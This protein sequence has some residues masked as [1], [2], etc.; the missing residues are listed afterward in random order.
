MLKERIHYDHYSDRTGLTPKTVYYVVKQALVWRFYVRLM[1]TDLRPCGNY[2]NKI[3][4]EFMRRFGFK[5]MPS[6]NS[7]VEGMWYN[8]CKRCR[9]DFEEMLGDREVIL[10]NTEYEPL[11]ELQRLWID[12]EDTWK[13]L[14][15]EEY[16]KA[17]QTPTGPKKTYH[18][19]DGWNVN[20]RILTP[21]S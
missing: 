15:K 2:Q 13:E 14:S 3:Q 17:V 20:E 5:E 11:I 7:F 6:G 12:L 16:L 21:P 18:R 9:R 10:G 8:L 19:N 1:K 4:S